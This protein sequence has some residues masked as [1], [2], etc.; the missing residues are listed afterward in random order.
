M[1]GQGLTENLQFGS[2]LWKAC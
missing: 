1:A 2:G